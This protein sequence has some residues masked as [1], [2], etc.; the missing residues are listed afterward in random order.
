M[1]CGVK[2]F[3]DYKDFLNENI[4]ADIVAVA[5]QDEGHKEHAIAMM[6]VGYDLLLEK[7]IANFYKGKKVENVTSID[8]SMQ[9]HY[10]GFAAEESRK[11]GGKVVKLLK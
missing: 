6:K 11:N 8:K 1:K 9:S 4:A 3:T 7:P 5:T 2:V 10:M